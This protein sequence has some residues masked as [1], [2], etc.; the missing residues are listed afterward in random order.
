[1]YLLHCRIKKD[2]WYIFAVIEV[3]S[4]PINPFAGG[5]MRLVSL[6]S[7]SITY[8]HAQSYCEKRVEEFVK[9][10]LVENLLIS[11]PPLSLKNFGSVAKRTAKKTE[12][13]PI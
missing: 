8:E 2:D 5:R 3:M 12:L 13:Q 11:S 4:S 7:V 9:E 10:R 1:M 6:S